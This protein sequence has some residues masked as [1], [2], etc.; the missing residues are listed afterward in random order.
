MTLELRVFQVGQ[1]QGIRLL[2]WPGLIVLNM[3]R[4]WL[5]IARES[6]RGGGDASTATAVGE[7]LETRICLR[8]AQCI[9]EPHLFDCR[10]GGLE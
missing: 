3:G 9:D 5:Q 6:G 1:L 7:D 8:P 4:L 2:R 10:A